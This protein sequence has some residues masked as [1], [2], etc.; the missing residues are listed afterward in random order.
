MPVHVVGSRDKSPIATINT[1]SRS[2]N[3]SQELSPFFLG[4]VTLYGDFVS[5]NMENAWQYAKVYPHHTDDKDEPT[6]SY[7][8]WARKGWAKNYA[9]RYPMG[10][11]AKPL[12]SLWDGQKLTYVEARKKIYAPLYAEL[13]QKTDAFARLKDM[14][15]KGEDIW[16]WDFDG[17]NHKTKDMTY[18]DVINH[19]T[20]KMGHA[21]VVAMLLEDQKVWL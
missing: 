11:G 20:K 1:T 12:Y 9:D 16:L 3:W 13:V 5:L 6:P 14:Y 18:E 19:P 8:E 2:K 15:D 21:F 17:Y 10:R 4:P 7:F